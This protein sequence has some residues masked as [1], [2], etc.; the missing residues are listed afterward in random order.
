MV[1][2]YDSAELLFFPFELPT[3]RRGNSLGPSQPGPDRWFR[4]SVAATGTPVA[5]VPRLLRGPEDAHRGARESVCVK[6]C[7]YARERENS[8]WLGVVH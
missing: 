3:Q 4:V 5:R 8:V 1:Q 7:V 2:A 6:A